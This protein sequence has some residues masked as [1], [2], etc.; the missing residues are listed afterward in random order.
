MI[1]GAAALFVAVL[2][3]AGAEWPGQACALI[4]Q[5]EETR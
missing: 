2:C 1:D 3:K 4:E 5:H